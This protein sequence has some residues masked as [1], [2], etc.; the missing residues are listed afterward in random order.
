MAN[1][2]YKAKKKT[3]GEWL[4]GVPT[5]DSKYIYAEDFDIDIIENYEI[6][7]DTISQFTGLKDKKCTKI[8]HN[9][10]FRFKKG[11]KD[12]IYLVVW[13]EEKACF[14]Y[15][16]ISKSKYIYEFPF[17]FYD[18]IQEDFLNYCEVIGNKFDNSEYL[19]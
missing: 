17:T 3:T 14:G 9:E 12:L 10:I 16:L 7:P 13:I 18:E 8:Y 4:F 6:E 1:L 11:N 15:K 5:F 2:D 19:K